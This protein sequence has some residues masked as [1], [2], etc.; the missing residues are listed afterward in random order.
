MWRHR[1]VSNQSHLGIQL[2]YDLYDSH[3]DIVETKQWHLITNATGFSAR[4]DHAA[5]YMP[6]DNSVYVF[7]GSGPMKNM[8]YLSLND[9]LRYNTS[10][11]L[12]STY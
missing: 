3:T 6:Y 4:E 1:H 7:G 2:W 5:V 11:G 10:K 8:N 12:Y 9:L